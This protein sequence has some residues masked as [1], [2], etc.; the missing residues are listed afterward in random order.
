MRGLLP[1]WILLIIGAASFA[2]RALAASKLPIHRSPLVDQS[3]ARMPDFFLERG[4]KFLNRR[5]FKDFDEKH[6]RV[7]EGLLIG[8]YRVHHRRFL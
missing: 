4:R 8:A 7:E 1:A 2:A 5:V 3:P 6:V